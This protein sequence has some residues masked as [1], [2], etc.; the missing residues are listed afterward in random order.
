MEML[1]KEK[2][3]RIENRI[4][5]VPAKSKSARVVLNLASEEGKFTVKTVLK[6]DGKEYFSEDTNFSLES[7]IINT[8][9]EIFRILEKDRGKKE[10]V[11]EK[12]WKKIREAKRSPKE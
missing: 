9:E 3:S 4:K 10:S 2:F 8:V 1:T 6:V 5:D 7:S 11:R 12:K